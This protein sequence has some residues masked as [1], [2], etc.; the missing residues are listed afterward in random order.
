MISGIA[1]IGVLWALIVASHAGEALTPWPAPVPD[2]GM[3]KERAGISHYRSGLQAYGRGEYELTMREMM[4]AVIDRDHTMSARDHMKLAGERI[5]TQGHRF[6]EA[7]RAETLS[8][9]REAFEHGRLLALRWSTWLE[10]AALASRKA[11]WALVFDLSHRVLEE[12]PLHEDAQMFLAKARHGMALAL[13][14]KQLSIPKD[15]RIYAGLFAFQRARRQEAVGALEE[16]LTLPD[17]RGEIADE[18]ILH[19]LSHFKG[20]QE[21]VM[22]GWSPRGWVDPKLPKKR[23]QERAPARPV[24]MASLLDSKHQEP[25]RLLQPGEWAYLEAQVQLKQGRYETAIELLG[26]AVAENPANGEARRELVRVKHDW[27]RIQQKGRGE[28]ERLYTA[29]IFHYSQGRPDEAVKLWK[30]AL[31]LFPE[32]H[33]ALRALRHAEE[34]LRGEKP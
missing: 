24:S 4:L 29:G 16:A 22:L 8:R 32:H 28:A 3:V 18:R 27:E 11:K 19:Y 15:G 1:A 17:E 13:D 2:L 23:P 21:L 9:H 20:P 7:G 30:Q 34:E 5:V 26:R 33:Y 12:N 6:I 14:R 10:E 31:Q 25:T